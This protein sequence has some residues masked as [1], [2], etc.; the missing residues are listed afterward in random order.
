MFLFQLAIMLIGAKVGG[1]IS[2]KLKQPTVLGQIIAGVILGPLVLG[3]LRDT[4][5]IKAFA[6]IG[7]ILLMFIAGIETDIN[8]FKETSGSSA[9]IAC[10]GV[11]VPLALGAGAAYLLGKDVVE[12]L[13]IGVILTVTSIS[14]SV[15]TLREMGRLQTRQG[16]AILE[17]AIFDDVLGIILLT[18]LVSYITHASI[19]TSILIVLGKILL[20]FVTL[21]VAGYLAT[22]VLARYSQKID[23]DNNIIIIA[24]MACFLAAFYGEEMGLT[25]KIGAYLAGIIFSTTPFRNR[26]SYNIQQMAF[27]VFT[28]I[29]FVSIGL[30]IEHI[31]LGSALG[32]GLIIAIVGIIGKILG[33]G[34]GAKISGFT[35]IQSLEIGIGMAARAEIA[36]IITNIGLKLNV[37]GHAAF[38]SVVLLILMSTIVTPSLL[39]YTF[40][41]KELNKL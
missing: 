13:F 10:F 23:A 30:K 35:N 17:A 31:Q 22:K 24:V 6:E 19:E 32:F 2:N 38:T 4:D 11:L 7:L 21:G 41:S 37:I 36:L 18:L 3:V 1:F 25:A 20:F 14:I 39:K 40:S 8:E 16:I 33:C 26:V 15:Q 27:S 9:I 34:L 12:S 29:F 28:P 5:V